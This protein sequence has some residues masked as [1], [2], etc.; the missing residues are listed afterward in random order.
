MEDTAQILDDLE[1]VCFSQCKENTETAD[2]F[3]LVLV[4]PENI[5]YYLDK[6]LIHVYFL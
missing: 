1:L 3:Q 5:T 2:W 4:Y 6:T